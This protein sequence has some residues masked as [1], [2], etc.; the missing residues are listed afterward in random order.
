MT[1][2]LPLS[3]IKKNYND[4]ADKPEDIVTYRLNWPWGQIS[5]NYQ[6]LTIIIAER[7]KPR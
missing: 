4:G 7:E 2:S 6:N 3:P 1:R 5:K